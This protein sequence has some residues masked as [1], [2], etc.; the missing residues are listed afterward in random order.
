MKRTTGGGREEGSAPPSSSS[1]LS[2]SSHQSSSSTR[3]ICTTIDPDD[4]RDFLPVPRILVVRCLCID[5]ASFRHVSVVLTYATVTVPGRRM[6]L[7]SE[8]R[9]AP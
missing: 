7:R 5:W 9:L 3:H 8:R 1:G 2:T 4:A 6:L